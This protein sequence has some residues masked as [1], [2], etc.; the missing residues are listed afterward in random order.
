MLKGLPELLELDM[1]CNKVVEISLPP[2]LIDTEA[3][4]VPKL[5]S[6]LEL[7]NLEN[8]DISFLPEDLDRLPSLKVLNVRNNFLST[9]PRRIC[10]M[11]LKSLVVQSNPVVHPP[12]ETCERGIP[13]MRRYYQQLEQERATTMYM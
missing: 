2:L 12:M 4:T 11:D 9:I 8:N 5:F 3:E 1:V 7:L 10:F 6:R 13:A